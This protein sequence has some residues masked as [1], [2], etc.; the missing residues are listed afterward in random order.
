M[1]R[2]VPL[3]KILKWQVNFHE[4]CFNIKPQWS[5]ATP[6]LYILHSHHQT[7]NMNKQTSKVSQNTEQPVTNNGLG[8]ILNAYENYLIWLWRKCG[9]L[10]KHNTVTPHVWQAREYA[11]F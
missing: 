1:D 3:S 5:K 7:N 9:H 8:R 10:P 2:Q 11:I 4:N 6:S